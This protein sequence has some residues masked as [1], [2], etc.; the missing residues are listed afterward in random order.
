MLMYRP[1]VMNAQS[2]LP[3]TENKCYE[4]KIEK[5]KKKPL[6]AGSQTHD[7]GLSRQCSATEP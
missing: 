2:I 6:V 5:N 3:H 7:T 4:A 1:L